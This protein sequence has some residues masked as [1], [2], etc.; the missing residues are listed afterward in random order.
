VSDRAQDIFA[1]VLLGELGVCSDVEEVRE[2][3]I[4]QAGW[5]GMLGYEFNRNLWWWFL[6]HFVDDAEQRA[7]NRAAADE[8]RAA[9]IDLAK[10]SYAETGEAKPLPEPLIRC[11]ERRVV[12]KLGRSL[13]KM[14]T[15]SVVRPT[16]RVSEILK[17]RTREESWLTKSA[18]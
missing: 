15:G 4:L 17:A 2:V 12:G 10:L 5:E 14:A 13:Y 16:S 7:R 3:P 11:L 9:F 18:S 6:E 8:I 1:D